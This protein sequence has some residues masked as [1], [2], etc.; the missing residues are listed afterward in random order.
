M[1]YLFKNKHELK[2]PDSL[3][4]VLHLFTNDGTK[5]EESAFPPHIV[6]LIF[7]YEEDGKLILWKPPF[8]S[9][10][11][12]HTKHFSDAIREREIGNDPEKVY[13]IG[14]FGIGTDASIALDY[15]LNE[16]SPRVICSRWNFSDNR[17]NDEI[18]WYECSRSVE[19]LAD[20]LEKYSH[21]SQFHNNNLL[22]SQQ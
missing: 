5:W 19:Y 18:E 7:P 14:D 11:Y 6:K 4:K 10:L 8:R 13:S 2:F 15:N 1:E 17:E 16:K 20:Q 3:K 9:I 21:H 22:K 12:G